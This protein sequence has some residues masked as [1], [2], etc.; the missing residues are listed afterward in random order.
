M[1][2]GLCQLI[3]GAPLTNDADPNVAPPNVARIF[4]LPER[5]DIPGGMLQIVGLLK[6]GTSCNFTVWIWSAEL[7]VWFKVGDTTNTTPRLVAS[8]NEVPAESVVFIQ[9]TNINGAP[10]KFGVVIGVNDSSSSSSN[11]SD[12]AWKQPVRLATTV[13]LPANTRVGNTMTANANGVLPNIDGIAAVVTNDVLVKN[14][15][16]GASHINDGIWRV[17][18]LGVADPGGSPWILERSPHC[19]ETGEVFDGMMVVTAEGATLAGHVFEQV[20][21]MPITIN[22]TAL[23]FRDLGT[24]LALVTTVDSGTVGAFGVTDG[25]VFGSDGITPGGVWRND[26]NVRPGAITMPTSPTVNTGAGVWTFGTTAINVGATV[27]ATTFGYAADAV[28]GGVRPAL[29][30]VGQDSSVAGST[31][32]LLSLRGGDGVDTGGN[33]EMRPG[34][35][36]MTHGLTTIFDADGTT[37]RFGTSSTGTWINASGTTSLRV[38]ALDVF[39]VTSSVVAS[40]ATTL[41]F[42]SAVVAPSIIHFDETAGIASDAMLIHSQDNTYTTAPNAVGG[43][44]TVRAGDAV[45]GAGATT[46]GGK[47][48]LRAGHGDTHGILALQAADGTDRL[49][50]DTSNQIVFKNPNGIDLC[51]VA[52]TGLFMSSTGV[53]LEYS[54]L[55]ASAGIFQS[56]TPTVGATGKTFTLRA[57]KA[58]DT[59]VTANVGG[60][61]ALW[62]GDAAGNNVASTGGAVQIKGGDAIAAAGIG[63]TVN[64]QP[65]HGAT[66]H[67]S[68]NLKD[69]V[70]TNRVSVDINGNITLG[71]ATYTQLATANYLYFAALVAAPTIQHYDDATAAATGKLLTVQAQ[72]TTAADSLVAGGLALKGGASSGAAGTGGVAY[73]QAGHGAT[74]GVASIKDPHGVDRIYVDANENVYLNG[75]ALSSLQVAGSNKFVARTTWFDIYIPAFYWAAN[76]T[77]PILNQVAAATAGA[78]GSIFTV[79]AQTASDT[80]IKNIGGALALLAGDAAGST[81]DTVGGAAYLKGGSATNVTNGIGGAAYIQAGHGATTHGVASIKDVL[82]VDRIFVDA[83][84]DVYMKGVTRAQMVIGAST[85]WAAYATYLQSIVPI[86][87]FSAVVV[88]PSISH[89]TD[90]TAAISGD[91]FTI[92]AQSLSAGDALVAGSLH[93]DGGASA[94]A[95]GTGGNVEVT[96]GTCAAGT[97]GDV[98]I[99][100]GT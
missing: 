31:G 43:A 1:S 35:G 47:L 38:G 59:T 46:T 4:S 91:A 10:T 78:T 73:I 22:V 41:R 95:A 25:Q 15:G 49:I 68:L 30:I 77:S 21:S 11:T 53:Q 48:A 37:V 13:A 40:N 97:G 62:G 85:V 57:Q 6:D 29:T 2:F 24:L 7:A 33:L 17:V 18:Q 28:T 12:D 90:T 3:S 82:G 65:G 42:N 32:G 63:G 75:L 44:L 100:P 54:Y 83:S 87:N 9:L 26:I 34:H 5:H 93:L 81:V 79:S 94:G 67:G 36:A 86:I 61:L 27:A 64:I 39:Y 50:V 99:R 69:A 51:S 76:V 66:T 20:T 96:A 56:D 72:N 84:E 8:V 60:L 92:A 16:G 45:Q 80:T 19:D 89:Q 74:L 98:I 14:E 70:G 52:A 58:G 23:E 71:G 55:C 88:A